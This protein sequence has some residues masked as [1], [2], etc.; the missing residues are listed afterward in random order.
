MS[1]PQRPNP[2]IVIRPL[3]AKRI[4]DPNLWRYRN[5]FFNLVRKDIR[6]SNRSTTLAFLW[7]SSS[8]LAMT[9]IFVSLS[10]LS[11]ANM[12]VAMPYM[13]YLFS[14]Y[15]LWFYFLDAA[16]GASMSL[17]TEAGVIKKI[18]FPRLIIPLV[19]VFSKLHKFAL[20]CLPLI[21]LCAYEKVYPDAKILLLL[22]VLPLCMLHAFSLGTLFAAIGL[23]SKDPQK[24]LGLILQLGVFVSPIIY[25][26][27]M[28]PGKLRVIY[29]LNPLVGVFMG[30]RSVIDANTIFPY[31]D[32][33]YSFLAGLVMLAVALYLYARAEI[34]LADKL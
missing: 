25:T 12:H 8:P 6:V 32:V 1:K 21:A 19:P 17:T 7:A 4:L 13:V 20:S 31:Q 30:F 9:L 5:L 11:S 2:E 29:N 34:H 28:I 10:R 33:A 22:V 15:I 24:L 14:G 3:T 16:M 26:P 27:D 23:D 18:Y